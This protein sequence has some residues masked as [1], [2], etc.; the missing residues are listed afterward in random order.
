VWRD[1]VSF[2]GLFGEILPRGLYLPWA[3]VV[4]KNENAFRKDKKA[5][6]RHKRHKGDKRD[7]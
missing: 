4:K 5:K 2:T 7:L 6:K 3:L 1:V